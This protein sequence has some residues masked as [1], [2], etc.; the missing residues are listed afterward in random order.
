MVGIRSVNLQGA[1]VWVLL[2]W[3]K[4][5]M[6]NDKSTSRQEQYDS[7]WKQCESLASHKAMVPHIFISRS[8]TR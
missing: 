3:C 5:P 2:R 4:A 8:L 7:G 1:Y 6:K